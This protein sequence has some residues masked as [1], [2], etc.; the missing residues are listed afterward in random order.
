V[1][2]HVP[3][4]VAAQAEVNRVLKPGGRLVVML[5]ARRSLNYQVTIRVLRRAGLLAAWPLKGRVR[6]GHLGGHLRNAEREGL[7]SYLRMDR[8]LHANTDGPQNP[9]ARVYGE[10]DIRRDFPDFEISKMRKEFMHAPPLPVHGLPGGRLMGW[11][12]WVEMEP[13]S[14]PSLNG[15]REKVASGVRVH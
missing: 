11:H 6:K 5:Y 15:A 1:L 2:H 12:L 7:G 9:Y 13:I 8:F 14:K 4:I 3:D 10:S